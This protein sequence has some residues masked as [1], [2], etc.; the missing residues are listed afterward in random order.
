MVFY[1]SETAECHTFNRVLCQNGIMPLVPIPL[2]SQTIRTLID[3][4][5]DTPY[6]QQSYS[7]SDAQN[8]L[9]NV[10]AVA[11]QKTRNDLDGA[12]TQLSPYISAGV[13]SLTEIHQ[14]LLSNYTYPQARKLISELMWRTYFRALLNQY[15]N[16]Q[17]ESYGPY[18]TG[19][20][21]DSYALE[22]PNDIATATTVNACINYFTQRLIQTGYLHNHARMYLAAYI[23]H[24]R[25]VHWKVGADWMF[26]YLTDADVASNHLS[27]Q[28]VASTLSSKPYI[29]NLEN[30]QKY[31]SMVCDTSPEHNPELDATYQE[32][33]RRL[34][35]EPSV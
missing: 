30:V 32:L 1:C 20:P 35:K 16:L 4:W 26:H 22:M 7:L 19:Y 11:Y 2:S 9:S 27:W 15:P 23:V 10:D 6:P 21:Q 34:F 14:T 33:S 24:Y 8:K 12:V 13:I 18:K 29:F 3:A 17:V 5:D 25:H 28:W 31:A